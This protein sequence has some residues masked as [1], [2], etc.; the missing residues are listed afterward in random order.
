M[1]SAVGDPEE[2]QPM[3]LQERTSSPPDRVLKV[4]GDML[5]IKAVDVSPQ[6]NCVVL[7][8]LLKS[9]P[10]SLFIP[11]SWMTSVIPEFSLHCILMTSVFICLA[12]VC[13]LL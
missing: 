10:F 1:L 11:P 4:Q 3:T 2:V 5:L 12:H 8:S 9:P 7:H 6:E 13:L